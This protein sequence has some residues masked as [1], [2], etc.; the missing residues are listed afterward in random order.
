MNKFK[1]NIQGMTCAGCEKHV[2]SALEKIGAKNIESSFRRGEAVFELPNEIEVESAIK[3]IDEANYKAREIEEVSSLEN[4]ALSNEDNYDLLIIGSGA[5]A[6]SSAI[7]AIEYGAKV[8]MIERGTVGGTCVNIGCVPSK[9]LLRAGEINHL[10]KDNPFIGLQTSAGEVDLASL[11]TQKDKLVSELRNQKYVDLIDEYNFDLIKGEAKF[12][13]ASTVEV[14]GTKLSAKRFL[15]ATGASPSLPQISGLEEMDYLTSTTLLELKKIPKRLTVIGSGYIGMELGQ[16]FH[17]LGSEI[18]LMQRSERLLKEYDPEISESVEKALIEQGISLVKGA[19]FERV[20]QS[21]EIKKVYVTVNGSKEVIESD[22]L[23]VATGR[24]PNTDSLNLSAAG[25]ETGKNNE[26]LINDFGQTSNEKIYAAG[27][28]TL[29]PQFVYVAAYEGGIITDNA[30]GGLNKK[31]DLSVVPAVTFTNPTVATVGLTEEQAKEKG[32]DVKTSVL[33][34]DAV[35]RAIV[36]RETTGVFKLVAD[37]ETL[38]VLGVHIV[39]ENA[40]DVIYAASL[41]VKFNLT[42]EDLT[43]TLAP[44]LTMAEGLKLAALTFDKNVS[45][46]SCCAV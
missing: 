42:I 36:N 40:G 12:V 2:E 31:I 46:L 38:K 10:S 15:I 6:F 1:V 14:N 21:E 39:S 26:I 7:K 3:A 43:E 35:P 34:L 5:A 44:Y 19:T 16:L 4:V 37:A 32:Y 18:T 23:L 11:I 30:I 28:V 45:K 29:G 41:A 33:P 8:G 22:Q 25:V 17:H 9:T 27:D 24:K 20:V 13:D